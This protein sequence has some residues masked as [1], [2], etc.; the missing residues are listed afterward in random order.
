ME[1]ALGVNLRFRSVGASAEAPRSGTSR[2]LGLATAG[3][4]A[5]TWAL[6]FVDVSWALVLWATALVAAAILARPV[7]RWLVLLSPVVVVPVAGALWGVATYFY[8][9]ATYLS[10]GYFPPQAFHLARSTRLYSRTTGCLVRGHEPSFQE[11]NNLAITVLAR[12]FGPMRGAYTGA[13]PSKDE[14]LCQRRGPRRAFG[15]ADSG[16]RLVSRLGPMV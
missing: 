11:P 15:N 2:L 12:A 9:S 3:A 16:V 7:L 10:T 6:L 4:L 1:P 5:L 14:A 8:G 13:F